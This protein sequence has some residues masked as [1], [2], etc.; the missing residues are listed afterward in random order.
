PEAERDTWARAFAL[1]GGLQC[2]FC[3]PG[4]VMRAR[5]IVAKERRPS[6]DAI[7]K[8]LG[9]HLCRCTGYVKIVDAIELAARVLDGD[10][11]PAADWSGKVGSPMPKYD[12]KKLALGEFDYID[13]LTLDG[14][15]HGAVLLSQH[16]RAKVRGFNFEKAR[17]L[18]GVVGILTAADVPGRRSQGLIYNDWPIFVAVGEE[19]RFMGDVLCAVAAKTRAIARR[20]VELIEVDY[21]VLR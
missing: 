2:G 10:S 7:A 20:A 19:T 6:R 8:G 11:F 21:E 18:D 14:M 16:P 5:S 13:D 15:L 17:A 12:G 9:A 1:T 4:I 3:I